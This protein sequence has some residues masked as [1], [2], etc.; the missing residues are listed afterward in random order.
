MSYALLSLIPVSLTL[1]YLVDVEPIWVFIAG[2]A[3]IGILADCVR[4]ATEQLA[5][6]AGVAADGETTWF[7][8]LLL[9]GVC[10][11][12]ALAFYFESPA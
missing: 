12:L 3:A 11:L 8:G 4:R 2:A 10:V 1:R 5:Q 7:E 6:R 9:V